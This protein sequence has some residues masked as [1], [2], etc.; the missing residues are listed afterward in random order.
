MTDCYADLH[1]HTTASDGTQTVSELAARAR[2]IGLSIIAI[3]DHDTISPDLTAPTTTVNGIEVITGV[4]IKV[5]YDG[6]HG[7][8]LGFFIDPRTPAL[9]ELFTFMHAARESRMEAM[10]ARCQK[11][12]GVD[13]AITAVRA[14]AKGSIGRPHL[15]QVLVDRGV[16]ATKREAFDK[17]LGNGKPCYVAL[18]RPDFRAAAQ[19]IHAAGGVTSIPHPC[20]FNVPD[21]DSFLTRVKPE[22]VDGIE[23]F[24]AYDKPEEL[25]APPE[26][27][28]ALAH[29]HGLL[30]TGGSDDHGP[31]SVREALGRIRISCKYVERLRAFVQA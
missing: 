17:L 6:I 22:G 20:L 24:Y 5:I 16:V 1:L 14:L 30:L 10:V 11:Y 2:G 31:G 25:I 13:I 7:E 12:T 26:E 15:A 18:E 21:W 4:E 8:L 27:I 19:A 9:A 28:M 29:K 3:T 23:V